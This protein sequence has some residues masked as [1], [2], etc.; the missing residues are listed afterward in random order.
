M[1]TLR[2]AFMVDTGVVLGPASGSRYCYGAASNG[3]AGACCGATTTILFVPTA[4][5][6]MAPYSILK[7]AWLDK[8]STRIQDDPVHRRH[9]FGLHGGLGFRVR[10]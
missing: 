1:R 4:L 9:R 7:G 6:Q 8:L 3:R 5:G 10:G 2:H